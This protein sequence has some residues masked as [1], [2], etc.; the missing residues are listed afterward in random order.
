MGATAGRTTLNGEGL[1]HEDGHS[2]LLASTNP[3]VVSY[4]PAFGYEVGHIIKDGL[5]RM[6]GEDSENIYYYITIY[7]EPYVQPAEPENVDADGIVRGIYKY[8]A[9]AEKEI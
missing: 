5:K 4:D 8:Q 6:Y 2:H 3:A 7:N 9:A 1:Q